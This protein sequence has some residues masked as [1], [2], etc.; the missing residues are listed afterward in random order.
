MFKKILK[1]TLL[2]VFVGLFIGTLVYLYNKSQKESEKFNTQKPYITDII[3]KTVATGSVV[4]RKEIEIKPKVSG[5]VVEIYVEPGDLVSKGD[6]IAKVQI[7]PDMGNLNNAENRLSVAKLSMNDAKVQYDRQTLL[8]EKGVISDNDY[9][10]F[11]YAYETARE[12]VRAA[13]NNLQIIREGAIKDAGNSNNI[14]TS[15]IS[16]TILAVP[17]EEGFSVI[18]ANNFN[19]GTTIAS[20][21]DMRDIIFKGKIDES[22]VGKIKTGMP[23]ILTV[24]AIENI[25]FDA[26]LQYISPKGEKENGAIQFEIKADVNLK[27]D[28]FL[29]AGY[30]ANADIV[31]NKVSKVMAINEGLLQFENGKP[32]VEIKIDSTRYEKRTITTGL[33]DGI[34]VEVTSGLKPTDE[35]KVWNMPVEVE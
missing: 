33:S 7:I 25:A 32:Y 2:L 27:A 24:G 11:K 15:T 12:E 14:V 4:P 34:Q 16:G 19:E 9:R 20:V 6:P 8:H 26:I 21:A 1:I 5:I 17:V 35:I 3:E 13:E 28:Q 18:E 22:E 23:L 31:L 30:S 10:S 29:R